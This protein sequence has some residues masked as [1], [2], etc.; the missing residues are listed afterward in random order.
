MTAHQDEALFPDVLARAKA[1]DPAAVEALVERFYPRVNRLVHSSL[2]T[3][4]RHGRPWLASRFST[5]D[6][7][8]E[9]FRSVLRDLSTFQGESERAFAGYMTMIVRNRLVDAIR[10]HEAQGRDARR[11]APEFE[12][13]ETESDIEPAAQQVDARDELQRIHELLDEFPVRE[14]LLLRARIEGTA[15]F[16]DLAEQLGYSSTT[17]AR[18]VFF[19]TR[20]RLAVRLG[21]EAPPEGTA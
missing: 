3:D 6:V 9:V 21:Y 14:R 19:E 16:A 4:V 2:S 7:V 13:A 15:S 8:Q 12:V 5:G 10:H 1:G 17:T 11:R 18:R 20:A